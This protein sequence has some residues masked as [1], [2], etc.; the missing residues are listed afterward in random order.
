MYLLKYHVTFYL[1]QMT[2]TSWTS[3][4]G[5]VTGIDVQFNPHL[6]RVSKKTKKMQASLRPLSSKKKTI[7]LTIYVKSMLAF[8]MLQRRH[9]V[10]INYYCYRFLF[11]R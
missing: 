6:K 2:L 7:T 4:K 10:Y 1:S 5:D 8:T 3:M 9:R 11:A